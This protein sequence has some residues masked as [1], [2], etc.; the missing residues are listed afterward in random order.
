MA[1]ILAVAGKTDKEMAEILGVSEDSLNRWKRKY[2]EFMRM[3]V[4]G[5]EL[6]DAN[7]EASLYRR[8]KGYS[9][10]AVKIFADP[11]T[12]ATKVVRYTEHYPPDTQAAKFWLT[13]RQRDKWKDRVDVKHDLA[14]GLAARLSAARQR[15]S[16]KGKGG[17]GE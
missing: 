1:F 13:N 14:D 17:K 5:K 11:K 7:I 2:P 6:A 15:V 16:P 3:I 12:G 9:H 4:E 8:A 10:P